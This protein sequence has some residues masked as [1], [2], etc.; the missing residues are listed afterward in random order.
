[1][2]RSVLGIAATTVMVAT[3]VVA[4]A[5]IWITTT[6][7]L[8]LATSAASGDVWTLLATLGGRMLALLW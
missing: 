6:D 2:S 5:L 7:P 8:S 4:A 1:M 3:T